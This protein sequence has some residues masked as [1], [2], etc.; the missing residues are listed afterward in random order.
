MKISIIVPAHNEERNIKNMI[1][2]LTKKFRDAE[3][4]VVCNGC[5]DRTPEIVKKIKLKHMRQINLSKADKG[6][7]IIRGFKV[8]KGEYIGFVDADGA[9]A[10]NDIAN[11]LKELERNDCVIASKWK[12]KKFNSV[13]GSFIRKIGSRIWN[14]LVRNL[15]DLDISDTQAGLKFFKKAVIDS[16]GYDFVC[17]GFEFD[18]ELLYKVKNSGFKIKELY[19]PVK[20]SGKSS[21]T[22]FDTPKMLLNLVKFWLKT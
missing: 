18:V 2:S 19:I 9:F 4:I 6:A 20:K 3:I 8:A 5:T 21:F 13:N 7:A 1:F 22:L 17:E 16:I 10:A 11:V 12:G 15:I 14:F